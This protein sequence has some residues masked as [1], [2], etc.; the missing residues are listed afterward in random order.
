[1]TPALWLIAIPIGF[2]PVVYLLRQ[3]GVGAIVGAVITL[4]SAGLVIWLPTGPVTNLLG[5]PVELDLLSKVVL[6]LLFAATAML[7]LIL[8][9]N[10]FVQEGRVGYFGKVT[11][12]EGRVFYPAALIILALF[13]TASLSNH[14][15]ITAIFIQLAAILMVFVIQTQRLEST[16]ASLRFL[17]L[18]SLAT[19][20]FLLAAWRIDL[21]QPTGLVTSSRVDQQVALLAGL[22]FAVWL[23]VIPFHGW[24]TGTA[25]ESSPVTTAFVFITFPA[26]AF[27]TF[28][29]LLANL[30]QLIQVSFL[31]D[32]IIIAGVA[33]ALIAGLL[34]SVQRGFSEL[35]GYAAL[36]NIGC[37]LTFLGVGQ[38]AAV[39]AILVSLVV[40]ALAL[41][42]IALGT[43]M[44]YLRATSD[45]FSYVQGMARQMPMATVGLVLGGL[46]LAGSPLTPGFAPTWQLLRSVAEVD[47]RGVVLLALG[48]LGV[49]LGYLRGLHATL[50][51][52]TRSPERRAT[53]N[54]AE[55]QFLAILTAVLSLICLLLG[56]YPALL[57]EP[58]RPMAMPLPVGGG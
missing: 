49:A 50:Q 45:G 55:P 6:A 12:Q 54:L 2:A 42:L 20:I 4:L 11:G 32:G 7:F 41:T 58:L 28:I 51:Q 57:I 22:G 8:T 53:V 56:L 17:V 44:Y 30:P 43:S 48:G 31:V 21:A 1:M 36:Y 27:S 24:L 37:I 13:V 18:I 14:L 9:L 25:G 38:K 52:G 16:R 29:K 40:R 15:G 46:T 39:L 47:P 33:T 5:R 19:P 10:S 26:V 34:A 3:L 35:M 23:A